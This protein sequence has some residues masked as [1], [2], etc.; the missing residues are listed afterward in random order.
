MGRYGDRGYVQGVSCRPNFVNGEC[1][2]VD[3]HL[4]IAIAHLVLFDVDEDLLGFLDRKRS[5]STHRN[6]RILYPKTDLE[7]PLI[8]HTR[9]TL[10]HRPSPSPLLRLRRR[11]IASSPNPTLSSSQPTVPDSGDVQPASDAAAVLPACAG[12]ETGHE[13]VG[14]EFG[15]REV[16][17]E[18]EAGGLDG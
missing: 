10:R 12:V 7:R 13:G 14:V 17:N 16:E 9:K 2:E 1:V 6:P 3:V 15:K 18:V 4:E 5:I 11:R 8:R